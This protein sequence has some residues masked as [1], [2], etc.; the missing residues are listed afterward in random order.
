MG[1]IKERPIICN[2][3]SVLAILAESKTQTRRTC[4]LEDVNKNPG[5]WTFDYVG[6][7]GYM[8][9]KS[10]MGKWGAYFTTKQIEDRTMHI[11]PQKCPYGK[12]GDRLW[13]R[14]IWRLTLLGDSTF[15]YYR[16]GGGED[17][18]YLG[19]G[20][21]DL[22]LHHIPEEQLDRYLGRPG[23]CSPIHMPRWASRLLLEITDIR[24]ERVRDITE[25]DIKAECVSIATLSPTGS[26]FSAT[27]KIAFKYTWNAINKKRGYGWD[28]NPWVWVII[29]KMITPGSQP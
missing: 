4:G 28:V 22:T 29:F 9:K 20:W 1:E 18:E 6:E 11:C 26:G 17:D 10:A 5:I 14:E 7:L 13:V 23:W 3:E 21:Q 16:A 12:P 25:E 8:T 24:V 2:S 19:D 27:Y 15:V